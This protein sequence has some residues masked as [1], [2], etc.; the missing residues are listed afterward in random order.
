MGEK[1]SREGFGYTDPASE[2]K[3]KDCNYY[4][5]TNAKCGLFSKVQKALPEDFQLDSSVTGEAGCLAFV[6]VKGIEGLRK[7]ASEMDEVA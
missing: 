5:A 1:I 6:P 7:K 4:D 3:C 2:N